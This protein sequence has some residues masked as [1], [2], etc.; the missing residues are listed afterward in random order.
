MIG[1]LFVRSSKVH[2]TK[3]FIEF[4]K[5]GHNRTTTRDYITYQE[6]Y[7]IVQQY[8]HWVL[9]DVIQP[10]LL[11]GVDVS[12]SDTHTHCKETKNVEI[13]IAHLV[14]NIPDSLLSIL[15]WL[16]DE[17]KDWDLTDPKVPLAEVVFKD[18]VLLER[19][20]AEVRAETM[21]KW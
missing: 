12:S 5:H 13:V 2:G 19:Y 3:P 18:S 8:E 17:G 9:D 7:K 14:H 16:Q 11:E 10:M 1:N 21:Q 4:H 15:E 6:S 20:S